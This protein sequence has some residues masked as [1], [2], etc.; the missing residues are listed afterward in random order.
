MGNKFY[1]SDILPQDSYRTVSIT[2][3]WEA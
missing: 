2:N 1:H 3:M